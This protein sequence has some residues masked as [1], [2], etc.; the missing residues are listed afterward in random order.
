M[1][2]ILTSQKTSEPHAKPWNYQNYF[3]QTMKIA[4][5]SKISLNH[6]TINRNAFFSFENERIFWIYHGVTMPSREFKMRD[7]KDTG[8]DASALL[9]DTTA[10]LSPQQLNNYVNYPQPVVILKGEYTIDQLVQ[11][12]QYNLNHPNAVTGGDFYRS[13]FW[14]VQ[15]KYST[16]NVFEYLSFDWD[17]STNIVSNYYPPTDSFIKNYP[18]NNAISYDVNSRI[19]VG[20]SANW[21]CGEFD[22]FISNNKGFIKFA[23]ASD[24]CIVGLSR[25][26]QGKVWQD[27]AG[28]EYVSNGDVI[29]DCPRNLDYFDYCVVSDNGNFKVFVLECVDGDDITEARYEMKEYTYGAYV[30]T[31]TDS[32]VQF[33]VNNNNVEISIFSQ[34]SIKATITLELKPVGNTTM[35]L[36]P[37]IALKG[38]APF[39]SVS[40]QSNLLADTNKPIVPIPLEE[41]LTDYSD[42]NIWW[43]CC[44]IWNRSVPITPLPKLKNGYLYNNWLSLAGYSSYDSDIDATDVQ[45]AGQKI[46][47]ATMQ[48]GK[49]LKSF[50]SY[51]FDESLDTGIGGFKYSY[52]NMVS[53][54][55]YSFDPL[56]TVIIPYNVYN[57]LYHVNGNLDGAMGISSAYRQGVEYTSGSDDIIRILGN[58][59]IA[60]NN[61]D[62]LYLRIDL[63]NTYTI[64]GATSSVSKIISPIIIDRGDGG[65]STTLGI[66]TF[67]PERMYLDI[68]NSDDIYI[69]SIS[70][71]IV[72][73]GE[74]FAVELAPS[75][76]ASFHIIAP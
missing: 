52:K 21:N 5:G 9:Q 2:L 18:D 37:K 65:I 54:K 24:N 14:T 68:N 58:D 67:T 38:T 13:G 39:V 61:N 59:R 10:T 64:N 20:S 60:L 45:N 76:S 8:G 4:K 69:N 44:N 3:S 57:T 46:T 25:V 47:I 48:T 28:I 12:L 22:R 42:C 33:I 50:W 17:V 66:R 29:L 1:S 26:T 63:G 71:S 6:I 15:A 40:P 55:E 27:F 74:R 72:T 30:T 16:T 41:G 73:K 36:V 53:G 19:V 32:T 23:V 51:D 11:T 7:M 35:Q 49:F 70:V 34:A 43:I 31:Y 62:I 56:G 75:T